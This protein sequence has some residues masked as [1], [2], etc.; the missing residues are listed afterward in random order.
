MKMI[1]REKVQ[2]LLL[3]SAF[4]FPGFFCS[5]KSSKQPVPSNQILA[6]V[7][8]DTIYVNDFI[9]RCEFAIRPVYCRENN[10]QDKR[11]CLNSLI[12]EKLFALEAES[13]SEF[14]HR[15]SLQARLQG[16]KEQA[17]RE[18]LIRKMV[19]DQIRIPQEK[20]KQAYLNSKKIVHTEAVFIPD[21]YNADRIYQD[22]LH[23]TSLDELSK[24]IK[25]DVK[26]GQIDQAIQS[27]VF[28][29]HVKKGT[30]LY[31]VEMKNGYRLIKVLGWSEDI[32]MSQTNRDLQMQSIEKRLRDYYVQRN[33]RQYAQKLMKGKRIDFYEKGWNVVLTSL[34]PIYLTRA[35]KPMLPLSHFE[36]EI[37]PLQQNADLPFLTV[38]RKVWTISDFRRALQKHPLEI[39]SKS[40][41]KENFPNR[42]Q[43]AI[44]GLITD[45]YLTKLAYQKKYDQSFAVKRVVNDW[46]THYLFLYSRDQY[47]KE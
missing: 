2:L 33:Y 18:R 16:I 10:I 37:L 45:T 46:K 8:R 31:P 41:T 17:M 1:M 5:K 34:R 4:I 20:I 22:A 14:V 25:Q 43:A 40:L 11:I 28:N 27:A 39:D 42:L 32:E 12:A 26:W 9:R 44:A 29:N 35:K 38:D 19:V 7:A 47:L 23:G 13:D 30:V 24:I 3:L 36:K 15:K 21:N 6:V